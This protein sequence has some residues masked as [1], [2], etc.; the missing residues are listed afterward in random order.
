LNN[1]GFHAQESISFYHPLAFWIGTAAV[2]FGVLAHIPMFIDSA[3]MNYHMA[4]MKMSMLMM[5][6]MYAIVAG[7]VVVAYGLLPRNVL[8]IS[9]HMHESADMHVHALDNAVLTP[10]HWKLFMV[11]IVALIVDVMKPATL[12][13]VV[14][15]TAVEYGISKAQVALLPMSG[16]L[17]TTIGSFL[18]GWLG[19]TIGRRAA[20]L[21]AAMIFIGTAICG[22]MP[23]FSWNIFMCFLMGFGA[24]GMLPITFALLAEIVPARHR[25]WM[26]VTLGSIGTIGGYLAASGSAAI[27]E[28]IFG[29]R[30]MW[31]LG[32]PTGLV[33]IILNRYIPE[34]PRFLL[35]QGNKKEAYRVMETFGVEIV[36]DE[37][38][39]IGHTSEK[40][41]T[42][43]AGNLWEI[44]HHPFTGLT[45]GVGL[46]GIAW[47][48]VNFGFLLWLPLN[49]RGMGMATQASDAILAKS[50]IIAFPA[51]LLG[52]W[53]YH[54]WS[55]K[56][57]LILFAMLT[58]LTLI[59][60][61][62]IGVELVS[63]P[64][65]MAVLLV[66]LLVS[67]SCVIAMLSPYTAE[68][69]PVHIRSTASG[70]SAGCSKGAGVATLGLAVAGLT[71]G[72]AAAAVFAAVPTFLAATVIS[73]KG[74]E[75]R[76]MGLEKIQNVTSKKISF[77]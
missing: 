64:T 7:F 11:L 25:G 57:T 32:L 18:W 53:L 4:G 35:A 54:S 65:L 52:A 24:G 56:K 16:I 50:A 63:Q 74:I 59:G 10:T 31:F 29:W 14:P 20:I 26:I 68:V 19:D 58:V 37:K 9:Q 2:I 67:S 75:T 46:Y 33:L 22:A 15:G 28:P 40:G 72:I 71:P 62:V 6:G 27:L 55:T 17:G 69:F 5:S 43:R 8:T 42:V 77:T 23:S 39:H 61:A 51:T 44:F 34:S 70:W 76:G 12:G 45:L 66:A 21:L 1:K 48:L 13:F 49:L 38:A 30:I 3:D 47:G 41:R 60:F 73:W 36:E